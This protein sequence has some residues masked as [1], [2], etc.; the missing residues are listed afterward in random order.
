MLGKAIESNLFSKAKEIKKISNIVPTQRGVGKNKSSNDKNNMFKILFVAADLDVKLKGFDLL[1]DA[2]HQLA[3]SNPNFSYSLTAIGSKIEKIDRISANS[4][5][6][7]K[8][9]VTQSALRMLFAESSL[10]V[11]PS[12][13]ENAPNIIMEAQSS[14]LIVLASDVDG[15][16]ELIRDSQ[17]GF[18][19]Q[20]ISH[21]IARNIKRIQNFNQESLARI[22]ETADKEVKS[23]NSSQRVEQEFMDLYLKM[24][25]TNK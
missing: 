6:I 24:I 1:I 5:V 8:K 21:E 15:I 23:N 17:T 19:T 16:P 20:C 2:F 4:E 18:L 7:Y 9:P 25:D 11:V 14:G 12:L 10:L 22:R 13:T 3:E